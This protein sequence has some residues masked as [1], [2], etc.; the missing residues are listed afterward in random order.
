MTRKQ[1]G[2]KD[3]MNGMDEMDQT[4]IQT[5]MIKRPMAVWVFGV[6]NIVLGCYCLEGALVFYSKYIRWLMNNP[7]RITSG[8]W[9]TLIMDLYSFVIGPVFA[10]CLIV[11]GI[12]L[13]KTKKWAR[14]G[15]ILLGF[16]IILSYIYTIAA[17]I[18]FV[19]QANIPTLRW[20]NAIFNSENTTLF[21]G[22]GYTILLLVFMKTEK[23]KRAFA[24]IEEKI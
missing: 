2:D 18:N 1:L 16:L 19:N 21:I 11:L 24:A 15:S 13:L 22:M 6:M 9:M 5:V 14:K 10:V 12:G 8:T 4:D 7:E 20:W 23:V 3:A 17:I